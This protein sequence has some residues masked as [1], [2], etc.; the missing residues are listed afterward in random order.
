M[1]RGGIAQRI[2]ESATA[3]GMAPA[4]GVD[5]A[6]VVT[7]VEKTGPLLRARLGGLAW[8]GDVRLPAVDELELRTLAAVR[9]LDE[10]HGSSS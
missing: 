5:A 3:M 10:Q 6:F 2:E 1:I 4:L 8:T 7:Q 9:T